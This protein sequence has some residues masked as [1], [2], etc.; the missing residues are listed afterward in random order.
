M[1]AVFTC[2][3]FWSPARCAQV[4]AAIDRAPLS[5]AEIYEGEYRV[6][7]NVRRTF[8]ADVEAA[9]VRGVEEAMAQVRARVS[10]FF[11]VPLVGSEG[12]GFFRYPPGGLYAPHRDGLADAHD[13]YP[14]RISVVLFLN[15]A[16][17]G[18]LRLYDEHDSPIDIVPMQGTLIA[19]P[20]TW[21]HEVLPVTAGV[22]DAIVDWFY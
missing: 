2:A 11:S 21:L 6:D 15:D 16:E 9:V 18:V 13:E 17:G 14:R 5:A 19:F 20:A 8:E 1:S 22:R 3:G 10:R 7:E 12:P 4:R